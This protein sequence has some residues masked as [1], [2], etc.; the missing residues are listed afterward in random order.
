VGAFSPT[1]PGVVYIAKSSGEIDVWDFTSKS[2]KPVQTVRVCS[3]DIGCI[4]FWPRPEE[5]KEQLLAVGD[6]AGV[7]H[8]MELPRS[9]RRATNGEKA[10][11]EGFLRRETD[12]VKDVDGR[13]EGREAQIEELE[14][15]MA[16]EEAAAAALK[17]EE[18]AAA[19]RAEKKKSSRKVLTDEDKADD[20]FDKME[21]QFL[22]NLGLAEPDPEDDE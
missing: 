12:R 9:L 17:K 1:R 10:Q 8:V 13:L 21:R 4:R 20:E 15:R 6:A 16:A 11:M 3:G 19:A 5:K 18:E 2:D 22:I 14:R 7:L